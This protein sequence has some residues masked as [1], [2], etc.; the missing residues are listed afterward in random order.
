MHGGRSAGYNALERQSWVLVWVMNASFMAMGLFGGLALFLLGMNFLSDGLKNAAGDQMRVALERFT[1]NR[2]MAAVSGAAV[3]AVVQSSSVTTVLVVGFVSAGVMTLSQ[4][5]GVIMGANIGS[6]MTA[7]IVAFSV[8]QYAP[9]LIALGFFTNFVAKKDRTKHI[10]SILMGLGLVFFGMGMMSSSMAP[11]RTYQPF[12]DLM[13]SMAEH[14][15]LAIGIAALFTALVQ[16]SSATTSIIVVMAGEGLVSLEA[17]IAMALGANI[18]TCA[19]AALSAIGKPVE[20]RQAAAVHVIFNVAGVL[21]WLPFISSLAQMTVAISP[22]FPEL[23]GLERLAAET[24]RQIANANTLF[25]VVNTA[26]FLFFTDQIAR[27]AT[28]IVPDRATAEEAGIAPEYLNETV[29]GTPTVALHAARQETAR[30]AGIVNAMLDDIETAP[31]GSDADDVFERVRARAGEASALYP[32]IVLFLTRLGQT[33]M[34]E[35]DRVEAQGLVLAASE[36]SLLTDLVTD[37]LL[38]LLPGNGLGDLDAPLQALYTT[39]RRG[40]EDLEN[41]LRERDYDR[42]KAI[43]GA[44]SDIERAVGD[45]LDT[46]ASPAQRSAGAQNNLELAQVLRLLMMVARRAARTVLFDEKALHQ[47]SETPPDAA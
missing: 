3:T 43:V 47:E 21:I 16:S 1:K 40:M 10:G 17:G 25:N 33:D 35:I 36:L 34:R 2:V 31:D 29:L 11:L 28:R 4:S 38:P 18:G 44:K 42:A 20:A 46:L 32:E 22:A 5:V 13:Q 12:I 19:T 39:M 8:E 45:L 41:V 24:P 6:T 7:Q 27:L 9:A 26:I 37:R 14:P 15:L 23:Q 30:L